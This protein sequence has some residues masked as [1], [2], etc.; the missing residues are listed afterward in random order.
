MESPDSIDRAARALKNLRSDFT[1]TNA[2]TFAELVAQAPAG[3]FG[4][5]PLQYIPGLA[6]EPA[7]SVHTRG[8][9]PKRDATTR[10]SGV[11]RLAHREV[12]AESPV[13]VVIAGKS[14]QLPTRHH[15]KLLEN[16]IDGAQPAVGSVRSAA[17]AAG[18]ELVKLNHGE[19]A[20]RKAQV[21]DLIVGHSMDG[22][23][24]GDGNV[25]LASGSTVPVN[26]ADLSAPIEV[27][28]D[29]GRFDSILGWDCVLTWSNRSGVIVAGSP[30][31]GKTGSLLPILAGLGE[32]AEIHYID[33]KGPT[34]DAASIAPICRTVDTTGDI[35][36]SSA[37]LALLRSIQH[38]VNS[39]A[40]SAAI[41]AL[42]EGTNFWGI[43]ASARAA[44]GL[45]PIVLVID[46]CQTWF[47]PSPSAS[48]S[49]RAACDEVTAIIRGLIQRGRALG[50]TVIL[51]TQ[52]PDL[53]TI[54][55]A[56][57]DNCDLRVVFRTASPQLAEGLL[58]RD[59]PGT[60]SA[61]IADLMRG[62][63]DP[64]RCIVQVE[65][66]A[67]LLTR[68]FYLQHRDLVEAVKQTTPVQD[69]FNQ[70]WGYPL[71]TA[72][73]SFERG[74]TPTSPA[75]CLEQLQKQI[76]EASPADQVLTKIEMILPKL[77]AAEKMRRLGRDDR[78]RGSRNLRIIGAPESGQARLAELMTRALYATGVIPHL[79]CVETR[80]SDLLGAVVGQA[81]FLT[82]STVDRAEGGVLYIDGIDDLFDERGSA[83]PF[84]DSVLLTLL[85]ELDARWEDLVVVLSG[86]EAAMR[87]LVDVPGYSG[88]FR[89]GID[90]RIPSAQEIAMTVQTLAADSES[91][92]TDAD[93]RALGGRIEAL[94]KQYPNGD[95]V[96][97]AGGLK[98]ASLLLE[99]AEAARAN[100]LGEVE[101]SSLSDEELLGLTDSD[102]GE[103]AQAVYATIMQ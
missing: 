99:E 91:I 37:L 88:R 103:A 56:I 84:G 61:M 70:A 45:F 62:R 11:F 74:I 13:S 68:A 78:D 66:E 54:P 89:D 42:N 14:Y 79:R 25:V 98:L 46:E 21:G 93:T 76:S 82:A 15:A 19:M 40:R 49:E 23:A 10:A 58:A 48:A 51:T 47:S 29:Q 72:M 71:S 44:A 5:R 102:L 22:L 81:E 31:A 87:Q 36:P 60:T 30:G 39:S 94:C 101:L 69:Q 20:V 38:L 7:R 41:V 86:T 59:D 43:D 83:R 32:H 18:F 26:G 28:T 9:T 1:R 50:I 55:A 75:E 97:A 67:P 33:G 24:L 96:R 77:L 12:S 80:A 85:R 64:G 52:R 90:L 16:L 95:F 2:R 6:D 17:V 57:R 34:L 53:R 8:N 100:R 3:V 65:G 4:Q 27:V 63:P 73:D 92:I 35:G